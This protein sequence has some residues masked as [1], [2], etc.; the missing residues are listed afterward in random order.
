MPLA[1][2]RGFYRDSGTLENP[3]RLDPTD[4]IRFSATVRHGESAPAQQ[5]TDTADVRTTM[6]IRSQFAGRGSK[7]VRLRATSEMQREILVA[8]EPNFGG[9]QRLSHPATARAE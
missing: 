9:C 7:L 1:N 4:S 2:G 6:S 8:S 3:K 5:V